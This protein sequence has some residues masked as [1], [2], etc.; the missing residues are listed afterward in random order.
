MNVNDYIHNVSGE[1]PYSD[2]LKQVQNFVSREC[3]SLINK[4]NMTNDDTYNLRKHIE[5]FITSYN[6]KCKDAESIDDVVSKVYNDMVG[7]SFLTDYLSDKKVKEMGIEEI[8]VN[9]WDCIYLKTKNGKIKIPETF[10]TPQH[11]IDIVQRILRRSGSTIDNAMPMCLGQVKKNVRIAA[12]KAPVLDEEVGIAVSIRIVNFSEL[13]D[14]DLIDNG[15]ANEDMIN[16]LLMFLKS[17][18]SIVICGETGCGK[19]GT[20]GMLLDLVT[21][22]DTYRV[23]TVEEGSRELNLVKRDENGNVINDVVH[24]ITRPSELEKYN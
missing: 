5:N 20:I 14:K 1:T 2:V 8:N 6:I 9:S 11:A 3:P 21:Q 23:L 10:N 7:F 19:T 24:M 17:K 4:D 16:C 18:T 15:T 22:D 12:I 13:T